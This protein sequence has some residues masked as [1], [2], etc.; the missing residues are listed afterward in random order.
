[1]DGL[2]KCSTCG[3]EKPRDEFYNS[4]Q[5]KDGLRYQCKACTK[6]AKTKWASDNPQLVAEQKRRYRKKNPNTVRAQK[7]RTQ[8]RRLGT[9]KGRLDADIRTVM[10]GNIRLIKTHGRDAYQLLGYTAKELMAHIEGNLHPG[11]TWKNHSLRG[12]H[13]DHVHPLAAYS[14]ECPT[15][16]AFKSA[17]SLAN[18]MPLWAADNIAKG[19][20]IPPPKV[21]MAA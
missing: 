8:A 2:K 4:K 10:N 3:L 16:N 7:A 21:A 5:S 14:Y 19:S 13:I 20:Q 15:S 18:Q 1:M 6:E 12:W 9:K 17:W 11:M